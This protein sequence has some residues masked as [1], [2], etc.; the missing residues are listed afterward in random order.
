MLQADMH[1]RVRGNNVN[2][3]LEQFVQQKKSECQRALA[4]ISVNLKKEKPAC[5]NVV[6]LMQRFIHRVRSNTTFKDDHEDGSEKAISADTY[7]GF[8]QR[9]LAR[10]NLAVRIMCLLRLKMFPS[11]LRLI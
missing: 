1:A 2:F 11:H 10:R 6:L 3:S 7:S 5:V 4:I 8:G 9:G